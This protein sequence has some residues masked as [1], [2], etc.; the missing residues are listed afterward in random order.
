MS[1]HRH[2]MAGVVRKVLGELALPQLSIHAHSRFCIYPSSCISA[3]I[4]PVYLIHV[5]LSAL[6]LAVKFYDFAQLPS[7][8]GSKVQNVKEECIPHPMSNRQG[9]FDHLMD[10][11][12]L[13]A[14]PMPVS[15][16]HSC[17]SAMASV[18]P[19]HP[20]FPVPACGTCLCGRSPT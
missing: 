9:H 20:P 14:C 8:C 3:Y 10:P 13:S 4:S 17:G 7:A 16:C 11:S 19:K 12:C 1:C 5:Y 15:T 6:T 18:L 2:L